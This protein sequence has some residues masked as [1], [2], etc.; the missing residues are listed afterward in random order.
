VDRVLDD[1][2]A[3]A[4]DALGRHAWQEAF[5]ALSEMDRAGHLSGDGL[6]LLALA[7][8][9]SG[10][11][12]TTLDTGERAYEAYIKEGQPVQAS[13]AALE[14]A[15]QYGMRMNP[16]MWTA[17]FAR[18]ESLAGTDPDAP[19]AGLLAWMRGFM[20]MAMG[21]DVETAI[22]HLDRAL[23][24]ARRTGDRNVEGL[25]LID[26]GWALCR[27]GKQKEGLALTD[28]A[29]VLA[30]GG[31][32]DPVTTGQVY[33]SM[34]GLCFHRGDL[35][36]AAEWTEATT[37]WCERYEITGFPGVCRV[38]R[39][40]LMRIRGAW[41]DAEDEAKRASE[42]LSKFN[43]LFGMGDAFYEIGEIRRRKGDFPG[44]EEAYGRAHEYGR[45]PEPG[46]SLLRLDQGNLDA[47]AAGVRR[48]LA[49]TGP[50]GLS[51]FKPLLAQAEI[52][53][54]SGDL[55]TAA[56]A[57]AELDAIAEEVPTRYLQIA[58]ESTRG[59]LRAAQG[60]HE[61]GTRDLRAALHGWQQLEAP[62]EAAEVRVRLG[63]AYQ[64]QGDKEGALLELR[65]ARDTFDRL[66]AARAT[67]RA[68]EAIGQL[69]SPAQQPE[70]VRRAFM[71]TDI[72]KSTDLVSAIGDEAWENLLSWHDQMLGSIF[73][74]RGGEVSHH[75]G[76][77]FFVTFADSASAVG[78]AIA[79]QKALHEHRR[80]T[81]FAPVVRIGVHSAEATRRGGD[82]G[83]GEVHK[84]AR[85]A[86]H[87]NGWEIL[88]S[89]ETLEEAGEGIKFGD[90]EDVNL[91]GFGAP[92]R[93]GKVDWR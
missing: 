22:G 73:A 79:V 35:Q 52:G 37:R 2:L 15:R 18:A 50:E 5:E 44:A 67:E 10:R 46:L 72:V 34:I 32:M 93:V 62:Y 41:G 91:K 4:R 51:R 76:D 58:A 85:I 17:W 59:A 77:G 1:R 54:A 19:V 21:G 66:G 84:A 86:A 45:S 16:T 8:W 30:V 89:E 31:E 27:I 92:V 78:C 63:K 88:A 3:S 40:E 49:E 43:L 71:F 69:T 74:A 39:A 81:G 56:L 38:H 90:L 42:E 61:A 20:G 64:A 24:I 47:A 12:E 14:L 29:M 6:A 36:R 65:A 33:C 57:S 70:R 75:T 23:E 28:E 80:L 83:G 13:I 7:S 68:A 53:I 26:K 9:W 55:E 11:P 25:S 60:D 87:A 82:Y 48:A